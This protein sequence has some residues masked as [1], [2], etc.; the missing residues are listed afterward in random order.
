[1][2]STNTK[3]SNRDESEKTSTRHAS[4]RHNIIDK[5][6][7]DTNTPRLGRR[8]SEPH[9]FEINYLHDVLRSNYPDDRVIWDLHHYFN[10]IGEEIDIQFDISFFRDLKI[11][12]TLSS[13]RSSEFN[14]QKPTM[15]VNIFSKSTWKND[16]G[17]NM[18]TSRL[19]EIPIY[20]LF[21]PYLS[22]PKTYKAPFLRIYILKED[23]DYHVKET[24]EVCLDDGGVLDDKKLIDVENIVPFHFGI[25]KAKKR[26]QGDL[27]LYHLILVDSES[28]LRLLTS[29]EKEKVR[30]D[31]EKESADKEKH[32]ADKEKNRA[33]RLEEKFKS[34]QK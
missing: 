1:M 5:D 28:K 9:S 12:Y 23:G 6:D 14:N 33:D 17:L 8:E 10:H 18:D 30:T 25:M 34:F 11:P 13:F 20:V 31:R 22:S 26:H 24:R 21:S 2:T 4:T 16:L 29:L 32:R 7:F 27:P 19:L 15:V 3:Y